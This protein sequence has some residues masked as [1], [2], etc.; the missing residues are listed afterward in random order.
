MRPDLPWNVAGIPSEAREAARA[1]ARREGLSIGEWLTRRI[2]A[3]L[4][5]MSEPHQPPYHEPYREEWSGR[6]IDRA[7]SRRDSDEMLDRVSRSESETSSVYRRIEDQLRGMSRRL[8]SAERSQS[9]NNR[10]MSKAAVEMNVA[11]REQAQ[12]FD[13]LGA[14]VVGLSE[15]L[16]RMERQNGSDSLRDAVKAL[17]QGLSRLA[18]QITETANQSAAQVST[19]AGNLEDL[20]GRLGQARRDAEGAAR[21]LDGRIANLDERIRTVEKA[22]HSNATALERALETLEAR[23]DVRKE[24]SS[25]TIARLEENVRRLEA[26]GGTDPM[27]DRRLSGIERAMSDIVSRIDH[28]EDDQPDDAEAAL[29]KLAQRL[30]ASEA[31]QRQAIAELRSAIAEKA[32]QKAPEPPP[33]EPSIFASPSAPFNPGAPFS[34]LPAFDLPPFPD[35]ADNKPPFADPAFVPPPAYDTATA[36][37]GEHTFSAGQGFGAE[38]VASQP[39]V[40]SYLSAARRSARA[41]SEAE[42]VRSNSALGGF[43]WNATSSKPAAGR[44]GRTLYLGIGVLALAAIA[45][46][47]GAILSHRTA[48]VTSS[49]SA[50]GALFDKQRPVPAIKPSTSPDQSSDDLGTQASQQTAQPA[51]KPHVVQTPAQ[52]PVQKPAAKP[53][54]IRNTEAERPQVMPSGPPKAVA[55]AP[56]R[57]EATKP[58]VKLGQTASIPALDRLTTLANAGNARAELVVALKYLDGDGVPANDAEAFKWLSRSAQAG[59]PVA[60]YR[61]GTMYERGR[62]APADQ[63]KAVQWYEAAANQG[64][65]KAMHNLAVAYAEGSGV[66]KDFAEASRWF[67][68]AANLGLSDSQFNLAVLYERGLGV[69]QSL[70]NAYKWYAIAAAQGDAESKARLQALTT[71]LSADDRAAAQHAADTFKPAPLDPHANVAPTTA[72]VT[73][74]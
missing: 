13:Q 44:S 34:A 36:F 20:A 56:S 53:A 68:R 35:A 6:G 46:I 64:N 7:A 26:R 58:P 49:N 32:E 27:I 9:E 3:G 1:A 62:G 10:V 41:A 54:P 61:L 18:D 33:P 15:R 57:S 28:G 17:H 16:E 21:T 59:E 30:E 47:A 29:K 55:T 45:V 67:S 19:L 72:D 11:A 51:Q 52:Q 66:K 25:E 63:A 12:A 74:G 14:H 69:P 24:D 71:Q 2:L 39:T 5:D 70:L 42:A 22:A 23:Q 48:S 37:G 8:D 4:S 40:D 31:A 65:R 73:R 38:A 60:Q 43:A 50:I